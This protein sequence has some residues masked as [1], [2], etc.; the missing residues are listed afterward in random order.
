MMTASG[1]LSAIESK[2]PSA[3]RN[4]G[5]GAVEANVVFQE[6]GF[7]NMRALMKWS[8]G[9]NVTIFIVGDWLEILL[10]DWFIYLWNDTIQPDFF[11]E[12]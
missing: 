10:F 7:Q 4:N 2:P 12:C 11:H 1:D 9:L 8:C 6:P 5:F 3:D